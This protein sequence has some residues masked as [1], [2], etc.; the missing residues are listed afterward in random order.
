MK[1]IIHNTPFKLES[2]AVIPAL[3]LTYHTFGKL[4]ES[5]SNVVWACH[6]LTANSNVT[7][8]WKGLFGPDCLFDPEKYFI[9]C[10]NN[11]GSCYGSTGPL[12]ARPTGGTPLF[13]NFPRITIR[14]MASALDIVR[15]E[16][17]INKIHTLI[18]G[19][20][21]GQIALEWTYAKPEQIENLILL[22]TNAVHSPWGI[23]FNESQRMAVLADPS[24]NQNTIEGGKAGLAAARAIALLSYRN[25]GAYSNTQNERNAEKTGNFL[26]SSYQRYQGKKLTERFDAYSYFTLT[27][28]MD[29]HNMGRGRLSLAAALET[30]SAKTLVLSLE[31]DLLFPESEQDL[32]VQHI[33]CALK[34]KIPSAFGHD[35]FLIETQK[36]SKAISAFYD[37]EI[38]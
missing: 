35:G 37:H 20:Q 33:P 34:G 5:K 25:Y 6:A 14:D 10:V 8:W 38:R 24:F 21:G 3:E 16:L 11:L 12:T 15:K 27:E 22:A 9:V 18:G 1:K 13:S 2:G 36:I 4:N 30:I 32:L 17:G 29:S 19:S 7:D 26:A 23:A 31:G 28:A